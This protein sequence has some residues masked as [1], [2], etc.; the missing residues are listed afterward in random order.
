MQGNYNMVQ[1]TIADN[2]TT[3]RSRN[4]YQ[5]RPQVTKTEKSCKTANRVLGFIARNFRYKNKEL[6]HPLYKSLIRPHLDHAMQF[7]S[8]HLRRDIDKI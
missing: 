3:A 7:W 1:S 6:I 4:H 2:R 5:Q 8:P